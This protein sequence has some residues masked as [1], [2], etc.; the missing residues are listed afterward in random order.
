MPKGPVATMDTIGYITEP[1]LKA[2]RAI[3]YW[4]ANR[5]DQSLIFKDIAS[6]QY[7]VAKNQSSKSIDKFIKDVEDNLKK[8]LL[9]IFEGVSVS[10]RQIKVTESTFT[11]AVS[12]VFFQDGVSYDLARAVLVNGKTYELIDE[13]RRNI[14]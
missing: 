10:C 7:I 9:S 6:Y 2:D 4:F 8:Y 14:R 5:V 13:G 1:T 3:A 12:A 11:L